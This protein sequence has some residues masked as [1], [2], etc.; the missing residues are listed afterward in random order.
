M[1][2]DKNCKMPSKWLHLVECN[3]LKGARVRGTEAA[4]QGNELDHHLGVDRMIAQA[5]PLAKV[6]R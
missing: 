1:A 2:A 5:R 3:V 4:L 6:H